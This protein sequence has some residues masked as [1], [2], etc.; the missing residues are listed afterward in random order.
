MIKSIPEEFLT[1]YDYED[2]YENKILSWRLNSSV[3]CVLRVH[4]KTKNTVQEYVY[5]RQHA[6]KRRFEKELQVNDDVEI[7]ICTDVGL[8]THYNFLP[9][10]YEDLFEESEGD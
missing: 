6:A 1:G 8:S 2:I 3:H 4:N 7:T 10:G 9:P 5:Q